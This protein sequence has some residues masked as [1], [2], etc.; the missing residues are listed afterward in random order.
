MLNNSQA[1][2]YHRRLTRAI[3]A[4]DVN[5]ARSIAT[6]LLAAAPG[7]AEIRDAVGA[8]LLFCGDA[9]EALPLLATT[10]H[11]ARARAHAALGQFDDARREVSLARTAG[12]PDVDNVASDIEHTAN[13]AGLPNELVLRTALDSA[14]W[15]GWIGATEKICLGLHDEGWRDLVAVLDTYAPHKVGAKAL[16]RLGGTAP[17][18]RWAGERVG[19]LVVIANGGIGDVFMYGRAIRDMRRLCDHLSVVCEPTL[20]PLMV[21]T[22]S[23]DSLFTPT[24]FAAAIQAADAYVPLGFAGYVVGGPMHVHSHGPWSVK[25][26]AGTVPDLGAGMHVGLCW[27]ASASQG[28][29]RSIPFAALDPLQFIEGMTFHSLQVGIDAD[30]AG[31][32]VRRHDL[33]SWEETTSL[34]AALDAVVAVDTAVAH[35][36]G[37]AGVSTQLLLCAHEDWRWG[38]R[39][40]TPWY[41][42]MR[43][44][45]GNIGQAV[46]AVTKTLRASA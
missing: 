46:A 26:I 16:Q 27:G 31:P 13:R 39:D 10:R 38:L 6:E 24:A 28:R 19:R 12:D 1:L 25:P 30:D 5:V 35:L 15:A 42:T 11:A 14:E 32:W 23:I 20:H 45:R 17:C 43:I 3:V 44:H 41:P 29:N 34:I 18:P 8:A 22:L 40:T 2:A 21:R 33:R 4:G 37:N 9:K 7:V 36:A